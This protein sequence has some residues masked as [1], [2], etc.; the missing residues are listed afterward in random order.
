MVLTEKEHNNKN[1]SN[2]GRSLVPHLGYVSLG[3]LGQLGAS[4]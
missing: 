2:R 4:T 3:E 1:M